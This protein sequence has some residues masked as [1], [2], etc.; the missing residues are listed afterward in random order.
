MKKHILVVA[1]TFP[2]HEKDSVPTFVRDQ[3]V[4]MKHVEPELQFTVLAPHDRRSNTKDFTRHATYDEYRF[5]YAWPQRIEQL[6]GRGI[7]PA[8]RRNPFNYLLLPS[9][10]IGEFIALLRLVQQTKPDIIYAHWFTPQAVIARYVGIFTHV[11]FVFT[12]HAADVDAWHKVPLIGRFMVRSNA[13][14][15]VAF[16]AVS[17]RSLARLENFMT[18]KQWRELQKRSA[19]IPMG[20]TLPK[21]HAKHQKT[22]EKTILFIGRLAEKKGVHYLLPAFAKLHDIKARL[23]IAGDGPWR[24]RLQ[25]QAA[26]LGLT[27]ST[28]FVGY[29]QGA[30]KDKLLS[31]SDILVVPSITAGLGDVEGLPVSLMEG[32]AYGKICIATPESG[33]DDIITDGKS[34]FLVPQKNSQAL[35]R[36]LDR[37]LTL[38]Q[39]ATKK[40]ATAARQ[41]AEQFS[42]PKVARQHIDFL[43]KDTV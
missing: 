27:A 42:W 14:K 2:A 41:C 11:P 10:F 24:E 13:Q 38:D 37:V 28:S 16:T 43:F 6:A 39:T 1:S 9:L 31:E 12:T 36:T 26:E 17:R 3:I 32:L 30:E 40:I 5:H 23:I 18:K 33:A 22:H 20:T 35:A 19:I 4:A 7:M 34:G 21:P 15:S 29:V 8:L 25:A